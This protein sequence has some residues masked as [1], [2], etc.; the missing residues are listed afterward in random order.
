MTT[1]PPI[2]VQDQD[3]A[4]RRRDQ[5]SGPLVDTTW[6]TVVWPGQ[7]DRPNWPLTWGNTAWT[8]PGSINPRPPSQG[9]GTY[10]FE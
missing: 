9:G 1:G 4:W 5:A 3:Q 2:P 7:R 10:L 8:E 6:S